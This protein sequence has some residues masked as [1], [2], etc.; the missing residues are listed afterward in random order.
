MKSS[1]LD[2]V[3]NEDIRASEYMDDDLG[4]DNIRRNE[5]ANKLAN[6]FE[7]SYEKTVT[8]M[9]DDLTCTLNFIPKFKK[10]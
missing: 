4:L 6:L 3:F 8:G 1:I 5:A 10:F 7:L 9:L 2:K